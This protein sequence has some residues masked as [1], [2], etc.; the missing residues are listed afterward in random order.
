MRK[1]LH[2]MQNFTLIELLVVIAIIA[3]LA[4]MLLP[5]LNNSRARAMD[6]QCRNNLRQLNNT[7]MNYTQD[8]DDMLLPSHI[9]KPDA[10]AYWTAFLNGLKYE[11][12][13]GSAWDQ[14]A[15]WRCPTEKYRANNG[16]SGCFADY[17]I[18]SNTNGGWPNSTDITW[19]DVTFAKITKI[20]ATSTRA[21]LADIETQMGPGFGIGRVHMPPDGAKYQNLK[22]RHNQHANF[23][24]HDGHVSSIKYSQIPLKASGTYGMQSFPMPDGTYD[25]PY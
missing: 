13:A 6:V 23:A 10:S 5:A 25:S 14:K 11:A 21:Q 4:G 17:G 18:N 2:T 8:N 12:F 24:F 16:I 1:T 20:R 19:S 15:L 22:F 9:R 7:L 3:I